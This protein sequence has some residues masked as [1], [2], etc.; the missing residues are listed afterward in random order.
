MAAVVAAAQAQRYL[1]ITAGQ[2]YLITPSYRGAGRALRVRGLPWL[3]PHVPWLS[4]HVP[5]LSPQVLGELSECEDFLHVA[6]AGGGKQLAMAG[7]GKQLAVC[8]TLVRLLES[9]AVCSLLIT[10]S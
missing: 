3:S 10:P 6:M 4:P 7:G 5:W 9:A 1:V 8:A 2:R